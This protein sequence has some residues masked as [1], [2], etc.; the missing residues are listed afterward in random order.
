MFIKKER[1]GMEPKDRLIRKVSKEESCFRGTGDFGED[2]G[3]IRLNC[4]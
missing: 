3:E 4:D 2:F 1:V